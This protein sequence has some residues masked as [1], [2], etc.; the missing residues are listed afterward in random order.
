[1][2]HDFS[3]TLESAVRRRSSD[4]IRVNSASQAETAAQIMVFDTRW[5]QGGAAQRSDH[6]Q[7][8]LCQCP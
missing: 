1:M 6:V 5:L 2:W 3:S 7:V 8:K 4:L